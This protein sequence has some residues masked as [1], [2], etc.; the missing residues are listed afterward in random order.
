MAKE[1]VGN[2]PASYRAAN[3]VANQTSDSL[4]ARTLADTGDLNALEYDKADNEH[5]YDKMQDNDDRPMSSTT[6]PWSTTA[7]LRM[8]PDLATQASGADLRNA[9]EHQPTS[10]TPWSTSATLQVAA[11][12]DDHAVEEPAKTEPEAAASAPTYYEPPKKKFSTAD[13]KVTV[14]HFL[15]IFSYSTW[16]DKLL[17]F[18]ASF[19]SILTG[20][21]LPLMTIVFGMCC[22]G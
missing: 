1:A 4:K 21:T 19:T 10:P 11:E 22:S 12:D 17:L 14:K 20:V 15:R 13:Y 6:N 18:A 16:T 8:V 2:G 7:T 5:Q 3:P 9:P